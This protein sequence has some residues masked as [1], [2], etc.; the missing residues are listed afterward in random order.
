MAMDNLIP[1]YTAKFDKSGDLRQKKAIIE[2]RKVDKQFQKFEQEIAQAEAMKIDPAKAYKKG[3]IAEQNEAYQK[4]IEKK[5]PFIND[6]LTELV[7][8]AAGNVYLIGG[9]TG[10]GKSTTVANIIIPI[11]DQGNKI[12]VVTNEERRSDVYARVACRNIGQSFYKLKRGELHGEVRKL[13]NAE[14]E[15]LEDVM[16]VIGTDFQENSDMVTTPEGLKLVFEHFAPGH[17]V[18]LFD[19]YQQVTHSYVNDDPAPWVHQASFASWLNLFKNTF[20]GPIFVMSQLMDSEKGNATFKERI[21]G[22]KSI[23]NVAPVHLEIRPNKENFTTTFKVWKDRLTSCDGFYL[24]V[25]FDK[26]T[27]RFVVIDE[28]FLSKVARW[29]AD[30]AISAAPKD[31]ATTQ[32]ASTPQAGEQ[33][34]AQDITDELDF[35]NWTTE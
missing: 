28:A 17:D 9:V 34:K 21:E 13:I 6:Y 14:C 18:I 11:L 29:V 1:L 3:K 5:L 7:P 35:D 33:P 26:E 27:G 32:E 16:T 31:P 19:Y 30:R 4:V 8:I 24:E 12:L 20:N 2:E 25:G 22:R 23:A 15:R 10:G